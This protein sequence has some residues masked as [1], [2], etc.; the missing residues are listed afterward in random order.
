MPCAA[1][2]IETGGIGGGL[3]WV[4]VSARH[5]TVAAL[6]CECAAKPARK[7]NT[8]KTVV[9]LVKQFLDFASSAGW[10]DAASAIG[11]WL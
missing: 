1:S 11:V 2:V 8:T 6:I 7:T 10:A 9:M 5:G 3:T 4:A